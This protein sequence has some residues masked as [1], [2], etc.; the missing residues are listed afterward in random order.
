MADKVLKPQRL[1]L[2]PD[3]PTAS[4]DF[5]H[6]MFNCENFL[7]IMTLPKAYEDMITNEFTKEMAMDLLKLQSLM[8]LVSS[9]IWMDIKDCTTFKD[10]KEVLTETF[11][12]TPSTVFSRFK[13]ITTCQTSEQS[14]KA[15]KRE[16]E[17]LARNCNFE[18]VDASKYRND[19]LLLAF[20]AGLQ[21]HSIRK[22]LLKEKG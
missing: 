1:E 6:W 19:M 8:N 13:L 7:K 5:Q 18:A 2:S 16:L 11:V 15:F 9:D 10:A 17:Q 12:K 14:L 20:I 22:R 4:R 21:S 3:S